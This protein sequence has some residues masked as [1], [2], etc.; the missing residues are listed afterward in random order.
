ME[1]VIG[2]LIIGWVIYACWDQ[3]GDFIHWVARW[4]GG[5][6]IGV[7]LLYWSMGGLFNFLLERS[8]IP[9]Q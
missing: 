7:W 4:V 8:P 9:V 2:V 5:I 6:I 3:M 1:L